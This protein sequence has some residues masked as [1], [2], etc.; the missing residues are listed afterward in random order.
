VIRVYDE[1]GDLTETQKNK[2]EFESC[3]AILVRN[4]RTRRGFPRDSSAI[5]ATASNRMK[6]TGAA[7]ELG[8]ALCAAE[9]YKLRCN[10]ILRRLLLLC[11]GN[12]SSSLSG[13]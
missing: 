13:H 6:V 2:G 12:C 1:S 9:A 3:S 5:F 10:N 8:V 7:Q 11:T 4:S